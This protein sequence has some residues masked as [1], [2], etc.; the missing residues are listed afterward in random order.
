MS[1]KKRPARTQPPRAAK[2]Q[3][4]APSTSSTSSSTSSTS[5]STSST[6]SIDVVNDPPTSSNNSTWNGME[7]SKLPPKLRFKIQQK[8]N[9]G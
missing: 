7:I 5:S 3:V 4:L 8:E 1:E 9:K 2:T 6:I